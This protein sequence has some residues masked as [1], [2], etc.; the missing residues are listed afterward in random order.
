M[1]IK[2]LNSWVAHLPVLVISTKGSH[3][4][5]LT[6]EPYNIICDLVGG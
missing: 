2:F 5:D 3:G 4:Y 1:V 6:A